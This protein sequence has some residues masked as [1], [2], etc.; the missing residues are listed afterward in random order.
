MKLSDE[1]AF[2]FVE[3]AATEAEVYEQNCG[4]TVARL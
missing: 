3:V 2:Q 1:Y 4:L